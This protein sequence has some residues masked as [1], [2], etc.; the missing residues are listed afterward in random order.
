MERIFVYGSL[1]PGRA[2]H[3]LLARH[4]RAVAPAVLPDHALHARG[5]PYPTVRPEPG[6][7]VVGE[8]VDVA[9][10]EAVLARLDAYEGD[11]YVR[12]RVVAATAAGPVEAWAYVA[13]PGVTLGDATREPS[14]EWSG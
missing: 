14:G 12:V 2:A 9:G 1:R 6:G 5:L 7:R 13:A 11:G 8:L 3:A 4:V 10:G